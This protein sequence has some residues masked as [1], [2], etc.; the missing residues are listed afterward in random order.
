MHCCT[1]IAQMQTFRSIYRFLSLLISALCINHMMCDFCSHLCIRT[2]DRLLLLSIFL[3]L[4]LARLLC[5]RLL[6]SLL[7]L[8][9]LVL[10]GRHRSALALFVQ[11]LRFRSFKPWRQKARDALLFL[12]LTGG[13]RAAGFRGRVRFG[14]GLDAAAPLLLG[15]SRKKI[16]VD[17]N[18]LAVY[19]S[20]CAFRSILVLHCSA[21]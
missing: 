15:R 3:L 8:L 12:L 19:H 6:Y 11:A 21:C 1:Q 18:G 13:R 7:L 5:V 4:W 17:E 9:F 14:S 10:H 20:G 2:A 16:H